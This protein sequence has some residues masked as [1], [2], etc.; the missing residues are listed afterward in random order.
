VLGP[1]RKYPHSP[2]RG[3]FCRPE[4]NRET[5]V[6]EIAC[7]LGYLKGIGGLISNFLCGGGLDVFWNDSFTYFV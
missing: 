5:I 6:S 4:G 1:S 3:N 2:H 7:V